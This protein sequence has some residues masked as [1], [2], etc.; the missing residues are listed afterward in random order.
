M[1]IIDIVFLLP[2]IYF[3]INGFRKGLVIE[4]FSFLALIIAV[5]I[6]LKF[7]YL[8]MNSFNIEAHNKT[9]SYIVFVLV[10]IIVYVMIFLLGKLM[11]KLLKF[12]NLNVFNRLA[13]AFFGIFKIVFLFSLFF[14]ITNQVD[15]IPQRVKDG[16]FTYRGLQSVAP[17]II[18]FITDNVPFFKN[19]I[20]Q[21]EVFFHEKKPPI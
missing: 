10:F 5:I 7:T 8:I 1:N 2:L 15:I 3:A 14:W 19:L 20:S 6:C 12:A 11:E 13:G 17:V 18:E 16:S 21:I 4:L 9:G